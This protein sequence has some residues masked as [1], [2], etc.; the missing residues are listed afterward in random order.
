MGSADNGRISGINAAISAEIISKTGVISSTAVCCS[1]VGNQPLFST[2]FISTFVVQQS[3]PP[4]FSSQLSG[5]PQSS[6][7][8]TYADT[9]SGISQQYASNS[10][11]PAEPDT[12]ANESNIA[13]MRLNNNIKQDN[14]T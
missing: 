4:L 13:I 12:T 7:R 6:Q 3:L 2:F 8:C 9:L 1:F 5:V 10:G 11:I 14:R